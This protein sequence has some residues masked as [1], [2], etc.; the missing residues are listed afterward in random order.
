SCA[1]FS[2]GKVWCWG[3]NRQGQLARPSGAFSPQPLAVP[4][5]PAMRSVA[6]GSRHSCAVSAEGAAYCWGDGETGQLGAGDRNSRRE[7]V[8]VD[9]STV[10]DP[11]PRAML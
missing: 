10:P 11:G 3:S 9:W 4:G 5:L 7:P 6:N 2:D 8:A 1:V